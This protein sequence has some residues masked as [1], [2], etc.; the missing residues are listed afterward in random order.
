MS[1]Y[2][3]LLKWRKAPADYPR[4]LVEAIAFHSNLSTLDLKRDVRALGK[5]IANT[6][7]R[8]G[9]VMEK[10]LWWDLW[11]CFIDML[12]SL[13][14]RVFFV[15]FSVYL[16]VLFFRVSIKV[17]SRDGA[18]LIRV[19]EGDLLEIFRGV[20][21]LVRKKRFQVTVTPWLENKWKLLC[22][23]VIVNVI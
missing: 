1:K 17:E 4:S 14:N 6:I 12:Y 8:K 15:C 2:E 10:K 18:H 3:N 20:V 19:G 23:F 22:L 11:K 5:M 7:L 9:L 13:K 16:F 21:P